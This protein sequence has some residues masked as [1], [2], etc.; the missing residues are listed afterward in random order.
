MVQQTV[1]GRE[2]FE[3]A[4]FF[5]TSVQASAEALRPAENINDR[6]DFLTEQVTD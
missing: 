5:A 3:I 2:A 6:K 4:G 1:N